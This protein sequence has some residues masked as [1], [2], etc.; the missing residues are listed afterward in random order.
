MPRVNSY[1]INNLLRL[2]LAD[3]QSKGRHNN[4]ICFYYVLL[5]LLVNILG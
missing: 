3:V 5:K 2:A 1:L 4:E